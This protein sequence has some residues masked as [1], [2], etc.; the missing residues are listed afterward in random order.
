MP[1]KRRAAGARTAVVLM[2]ARFQVDDADYG[3]LR[4]AVAQAGGDAGA[5]RAR[6][7][8]STRRSRGIAVP[9]FDALPALRARCRA[10][11]C[12]SSRPCT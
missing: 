11:T 5:R 10:R 9:R 6:P 7:S 2:P 8:A 4:E 1:P 3:R 12:S